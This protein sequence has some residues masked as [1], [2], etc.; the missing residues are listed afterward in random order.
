MEKEFNFKH[1]VYISGNEI[2]HFLLEQGKKS[3]YYQNLFIDSI[4]F[5]YEYIMRKKLAPQILGNL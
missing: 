5:Y 4:G 3:S 1:P 2:K